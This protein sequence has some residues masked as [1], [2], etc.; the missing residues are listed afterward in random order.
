MGDVGS[1]PIPGEPG[2]PAQDPVAPVQEEC[3]QEGTEV[4]VQCFTFKLHE[5]KNEFMGS[6]QEIKQTE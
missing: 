2:R 6:V 3:D 4:R 5:L 1:G